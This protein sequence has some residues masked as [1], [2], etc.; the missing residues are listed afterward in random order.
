MRP[1]KVMVPS[2]LVVVPA[3]NCRMAGCVEN[4]LF[5]DMPE[6]VSERLENAKSLLAAFSFADSP[7]EKVC[8]RE[9]ETACF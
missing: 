5:R 4:C 2:L 6:K 7:R 3:V 8:V 1:L 9:S